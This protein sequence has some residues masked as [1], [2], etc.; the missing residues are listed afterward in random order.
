MGAELVDEA[1]LALAVAEGN[2]PLA[3][4]LD[5]HGR[6]IRLRQFCRDEDGQPVA[7]HQRTH[8]LSRIGAGQKHVLFVLHGRLR[9]YL[10]AFRRSI[11]FGGLL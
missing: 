1:E 3:E 7:A 6:A 10:S 4:H 8:G 9:R 5:A 11:T 2:Q